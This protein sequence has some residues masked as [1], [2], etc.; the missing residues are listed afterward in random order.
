MKRREGH[1]GRSRFTGRLAKV[2]Q[3]IDKVVDGLGKLNR[4]E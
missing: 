4:E 2:T 3:L 1:A